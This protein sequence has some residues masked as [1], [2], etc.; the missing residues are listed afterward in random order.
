MI[1]KLLNVVMT[2]LIIAAVAIMVL[3]IWGQITLGTQEHGQDRFRC[4]SSQDGASRNERLYVYEDTQTGKLY[5]YTAGFYRAG[6]C[7]LNTDSL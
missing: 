1:E 5:L 4:I 2:L 7:E 6:L 3:G